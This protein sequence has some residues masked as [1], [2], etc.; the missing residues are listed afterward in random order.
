MEIKFGELFSGPGGMS[1]GAHLAS[2]KFPEITFRHAWANDID[3]D[4]CDTF[5]ANI[6]GAND[7]TVICKN[8][9]DLDL[10]ALGKIDGFAFGFP[11]NDFSMVGKSKGLDGLFGPL[12]K[13]GVAALDIHNPKWFVAENVSGL[14]GK[15]QREAFRKI[16]TELAAAGEVGYKL[17]PHLYQFDQYGVPQRRKRVIVVGVRQDLNVE[18]KVPSPSTYSKMDVSVLTALTSPPITHLMHNN[19]MTRQSEVVINR[20]RHIKPGQNAFTADLPENLR[21]NVKGATISQIYKRLDPDRPSYTITGSGG[22]G[23]HVY[24]WSEDRALTNRERARLQ[25]FPDHFVFRG[26]KE[27]VRR[28][29]GMA[30]PVMGASAVFEALFSSFLGR[31]YE[32]V[33]PNISLQHELDLS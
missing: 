6:V 19:E 27:S 8:V 31:D 16:L 11:C 7:S 23:T 17:Y 28:Q 5:L 22:G 29:I 3:R 9:Q 32:S 12:Y 18:F 4:A 33:A 1:Y 25:T 30:V 21:L 15:N 14:V 13:Y 2:L 26:N 24:H 10:A 20:L